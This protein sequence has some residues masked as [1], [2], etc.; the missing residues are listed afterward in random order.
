MASLVMFFIVVFIAALAGS[1]FRP[2]AW[3][4]GLAKPSWNPPNWV[5]APVWTALY[6]IIAIAGWLV[7]RD[8]GD[9]FT[10][11]AMLFWIAQ[12]PLNGVWTFLFFRRHNPAWALVDIG[13]L[14]VVV[15]GFILAALRLGSTHAALLFVPYALW[16]TFA[17]ILNGTLWK[18]N[19]QP[20]T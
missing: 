19:P 5:F 18:M 6:A 14:L 20:R 2:D 9:N 3:Y 11:P 17:G 13:V 4:N 12:L 16:V 8:S 10:H 1:R 7:W 15:F